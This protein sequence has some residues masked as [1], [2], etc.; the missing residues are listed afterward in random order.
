MTVG[1]DPREAGARAQLQ[2]WRTAAG[3]S[4]RG[5]LRTTLLFAGSAFAVS[6]AVNVW[7][8]AAVYDGSE[9]PGGT[10][11]SGGGNEVSGTLFYLLGALLVSSLISFRVKAGP[12]AFALEAASVLR[13]ARSALAHDRARARVHVLAGASAAL[14]VTFLLGPAVAA[15]LFGIFLAAMTPAMWPISV[16]IVVLGWRKIVGRVVP[17]RA[18]PPVTPAILVGLLGAAIGFGVG[19]VVPDDGGGG[20]LMLALLA[21]VLA[22]VLDRGKAGPAATLGVLALAAT[23]AALLGHALPVLADDGGFSECDNPDLVSWLTA[24]DGSGSVLGASLLGAIAAGLG[25]AAG[26]AA[27]SSVPPPPPAYPPDWNS[28]TPPPPPAYP[29]DWNSETP[30]PPPAYPPDWNS[31]TPPPPPAYPPDW[32]GETPPPP[33]AR[34]PDLTSEAPPPPPAY[35]PDYNADVPPPPPARPPDLNSETPPPPP[36]YPPDYVK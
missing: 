32:N 20:A 16:G 10:P 5:N 12:A 8:M 31:E 24:C 21:G 13:V 23:V 6:Y 11:A 34:P 29:P 2:A 36:A 7:L 30:P 17:T 18:T 28:E 4:A 15:V 22:F 1:L 35:P 3:A 27:G 26:S 14:A 19:W 25:A 9:T 33:P